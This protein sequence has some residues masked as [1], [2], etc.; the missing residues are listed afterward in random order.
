MKFSKRFAALLLA[1]LL[2]AS[3][4]LLSACG[5]GSAQSATNAAGALGDGVEFT[6]NATSGKLTISGAGQIKNFEKPEDAPWYSY[7]ASVEKIEIGENITAIGN[8]AFYHFTALERVEINAK[9]LT[10]IGSYAFWMCSLL[11][12]ITIPAT[13]TEVGESAFAYCASIESVSFSALK[14]LGKSAFAGCT[15]LEVVSFD[16][17]ITAIPEKAF[18]NCTAL[19]TV[20]YPDSVLPENVAADAFLNT[21]EKLE[22]SVVKSE[23]TLTIRYLSEDGTELAP[24]HVAVLG[25]GAE[26][27][28]TTP[29]VDGYVIPSGEETISGIMPGADLTIQVIYKATAVETTPVETTPVEESTEQ[30]GGTTEP[31]KAPIGYLV[32][33]VILLAAIAVGGV[34]LVRSNKNITKDSQTVRKKK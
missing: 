34:L 26:Y 23:A 27:S 25:K 33:L 15:A 19:K 1:L 24:A 14:V 17:P 32:L 28:V 21:S 13:V 7:R 18:M 11:E 29:L 3:T 22:Q 12:E 20:A 4:L 16:G 10:H 30:P 2:I 6:F 5:S 31:K 9:A 8:Y